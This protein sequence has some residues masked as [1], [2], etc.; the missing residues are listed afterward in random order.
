MS[1]QPVN[2][3]TRK[4]IIKNFT[5]SLNFDNLF[6]SYETY[7]LSNCKVVVKAI[8]I[9]RL[10]YEGPQANLRIAYGLTNQRLVCRIEVYKLDAVFK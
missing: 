10:F 7:K 9:V 6:K 8:F 4:K 2:E 1:A 5:E 3:K